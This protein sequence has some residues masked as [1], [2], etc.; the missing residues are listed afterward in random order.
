V[1]I[2]YG[3][4]GRSMPLTLNQCG[5]LGGDVE[6]IPTVKLLAERHPEDEFWLIGRNSGEDPASV[7][8]P[9]NVVNPW[10]AWGPTLLDLKRRA[11]LNH[12]DLTIEEHLKLRDIYEDTVIPTFVDM[13]ALVLWVGQHG[14]TNSP[15]PGVRKEG[16]T[17]PHDWCALYCG[18]MVQGVNAWRDV[19]PLEREEVWLNSDPRNYMKLRDL[20]WPLRHPILAQYKFTNRMK[21]ERYED[22]GGF[23]EW[24]AP[25]TWDDLDTG[26][27]VDV[28]EE[29]MHTSEMWKSL[30]RNVYARLEVNSLLPGAPFA[31]DAW[32]RNDSQDLAPFGIFINETRR[33]VNSTKTRS[34]IVRD[35]VLPLEPAFIHG[36]WS[37]QGMQ[38]I[39]REVTPLPPASY[40]ARLRT[41]RSTFTTP[42]SGTGWA[43]A[44]PWEAFAAG[45]ACFFHPEYD[46]QD[47]ILGDADPTLRR[48]LRVDSPQQLAE[49]VRHMATDDAAWRWVIERQWYHFARAIEDPRYLRLIEERIWRK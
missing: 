39:G 28:A 11:G 9:S 8:L 44:K 47:N 31:R 23:N 40:F 14:T 29:G 49:R 18:Y 24:Y 19:N 10:K 2:G 43:T 7:G 26:Y 32:F 16:L 48:W 46:T 42:A 4:L 13:D 37:R 3:K 12:P 33:Y 41:V 45:V 36:T 30:T 34:R 38:E 20:K 1:K 35:W 15:I 22:G 17:K 6:M 27:G 25:Q 5:N 21:H